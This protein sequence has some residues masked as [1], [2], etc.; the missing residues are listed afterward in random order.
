MRAA[1]SGEPPSG[2]H[3]NDDGQNVPFAFEHTITPHVDHR[4]CMTSLARAYR[5][6]SGDGR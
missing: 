5:Q 2:R 1:A 3:R 4:K 6:Q